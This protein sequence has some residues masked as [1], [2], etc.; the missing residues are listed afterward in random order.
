MKKKL[1]VKKLDAGVYIASFMVIAATLLLS[2]MIGMI[3]IGF[4]HPRKVTLIVQTET[5]SKVFDG[6]PLVGENY[7]I[8][9]GKLSRG[10]SIKVLSRSSQTEIGEC[11]NHIE[12][13]IRDTSGSDVTELYNIEQRSGE[14]TVAVR[15]ASNRK[16]YDGTPLSDSSYKLISP[17]GFAPGHEAHVYSN[18][19]ITSVGTIPN[20]GTVKILDEAGNDVT[21]Q[22]D[23]TVE[24]G[25]LEILPRPM[26]LVTDSA[27]KI[28]DGLP[29][30]KEG[31]YLSVGTLLDGHVINAHC[32]AQ[33][34]EVGE[35]PNAAEVA[36]YDSL[37]AD[38]TAQYDITVQAGKLKVAAQSLYITTGSVQKI[39]DGTALTNS[40]WQI[41]S[42]ALNSG[43]TIEVAGITE[44]SE[45]GTVPNEMT[46]VIRDAAGNDI[47]NRYQIRL[48]PGDLT[49]EPRRISIQ[50]GS[51]QKKYDG[52][53]LSTD[54][55]TLISGSFC[56]GETLTVVGSR[57]T[58]VGMTENTL[59]SY[60]V[61]Q[62][63]NGVKTDVTDC[64]Q[65]TY[66]YGTLTVTS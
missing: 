1:R 64:Y 31:W 16:I 46:F 60:A 54:Q 5:L 19:E 47:T 15:L 52:K 7:E 65:I 38:M 29:L 40:N 26:T 62:T 28:Y 22:Y 43:E 18:P 50:T 2:V 32:T 25:T 63:K 12:F 9:Y 66:S 56:A 48:I 37:G 41:T 21:Y 58:M 39:Y 11:I 27:S 24:E 30:A 14:L 61:Y 45:V 13:M 3:E 57:R 8:I 44:L 59:I 20:N 10:H 4:I 35:I 53:P 55:W 42:G 49:I 6:Q 36:V 17:Y 23:L 33:L 34:T 51:A